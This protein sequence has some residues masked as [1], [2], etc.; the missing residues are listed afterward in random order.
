MTR[1]PRDESLVRGYK[2]RIE[3]YKSSALIINV[4][5]TQLMRDTGRTRQDLYKEEI[6]PLFYID[7]H[8][9]RFYILIGHRGCKRN[10]RWETKV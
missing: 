1:D 6:Q 4:G 8:T 3:P 2:R 7:S 9:H 10:Q 5:C